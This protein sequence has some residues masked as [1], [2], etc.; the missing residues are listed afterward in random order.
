MQP[1]QEASEEMINRDNRLKSV[2]R[3]GSNIALSSGLTLGGGALLSRIT[4]LLSKFI[5]KATA[6]KGLGKINSGLGKFIKTGLM[7]G[8]SIDEILDFIGK[9]TETANQAKPDQRNV[10]EQYSP[11]LFDFLKQQIQKGRAP[12]EAGALAQLNSKFKK[13][14]SQLE[15]DHK[16]PFSSILQ[17]IFGEGKQPRQEAVKKYNEHVRNKTMTD[18]L[19]EQFERG[20]GS[21]QQASQ[22]NPQSQD[23][24][25]KLME[26]ISK[27]NDSLKG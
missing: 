20:Y 19:K 6:A 14:I 2:L 16:T 11:E 26:M 22:S 8:K 27:L 4:P 23:A 7:N 1:Y 5:P 25:A 21:Q 3:T 9:K 24:N 18:E 12:L 10:L 17:S 13:V 15:T